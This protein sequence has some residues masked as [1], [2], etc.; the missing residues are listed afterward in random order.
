MERQ[1]EDLKQK[2]ANIKHDVERLKQ[3]EIKCKE[4]HEVAKAKDQELGIQLESAQAKQ[5]EFEQR[6]NEARRGIKST[7]LRLQVYKS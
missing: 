1:I 7:S 5:K 2:L 3:I 6:K 4:V